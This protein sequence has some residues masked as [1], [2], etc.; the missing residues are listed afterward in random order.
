[1]GIINEAHQF[2]KNT[3]EIDMDAP[4]SGIETIVDL[5]RELLDLV[6]DSLDM[7]SVIDQKHSW[8]KR[9]KVMLSEIYTLVA[10]QIEQIEAVICLAET[11]LVHYPSAYV[12]SRVV[13]ETNL[14]IEWLLR[15]KEYSEIVLRYIRYLD[16]Q[17]L[18]ERILIDYIEWSPILSESDKIDLKQERMDIIDDIRAMAQA[19]IDSGILSDKISAIAEAD[20]NSGISSDRQAKSPFSRQLIDEFPIPTKLIEEIKEIATEQREKELAI[21]YYNLSKFVHSMRHAIR[22][23]HTPWG[24]ESINYPELK[25]NYPL[26]ICI[27]SIIAST[28]KLLQRFQS[29]DL[30]QFNINSK[31]IS[32]KLQKEM[33][34]LE[35]MRA[36]SNTR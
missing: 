23:C 7:A 9:M 14:I 6:K 29:D 10:Y 24:L 26:D 36:A 22:R 21:N 27:E 20:F 19:A 16:A 34:K 31:T 8:G 15:D 1:M 17:F 18:K 13:I 4:H 11:N 12:I 2:D 25:W 33:N 5:I 35:S 3:S 30:E 32:E 28:Q